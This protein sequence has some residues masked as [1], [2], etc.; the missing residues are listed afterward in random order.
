MI[1]I[2][3]DDYLKLIP[4][5]DEEKYKIYCNRKSHR[6]QWSILREGNKWFTSEPSRSSI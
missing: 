6:N 5:L 3:Q 1:I 2:S 4:A